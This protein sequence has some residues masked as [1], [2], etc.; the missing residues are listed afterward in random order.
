MK[1]HCPNGHAMTDDNIMVRDGKPKCLTCV[2][3]S[4]LAWWRKKAAEKR[5][6]EAALPLGEI[7][8]R[9]DMDFILERVEF[10]TTTGCWLWAG[11]VSSG[12]GAFKI[13][14]RPV[15]AHRHAW[16]L[17]HGAVPSGLF[18]CHRC[19]TPICC[20]PAH[21]FLGTHADNMADMKSKGRSAGGTQPR[22]FS[23]ARRLEIR[24][25][26]AE[27]NKIAPTAR[28]VGCATATVKKQQRQMISELEQRP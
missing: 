8:S 15:S 9:F 17:T 2:R 28:I 21:L 10:E 4:A 27:G 18:V 22:E 12:Y 19:D 1:S 26:L 16:E 24:R 14:K 6:I 20:N 23:E 3:S 5:A 13:R 25:L 11:T 7:R